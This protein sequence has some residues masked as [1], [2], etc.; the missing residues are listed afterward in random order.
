MPEKA[1]VEASVERVQ[2]IAFLGVIEQ[3]AVDDRNFVKKAVNWS[4]RQSPP[5]SLI[6]NLP[7][8]DT[9]RIKDH[10]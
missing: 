4:L 8:I 6:Q 2:F 5:V 10:T 9:S 3:A 7:D 1:N